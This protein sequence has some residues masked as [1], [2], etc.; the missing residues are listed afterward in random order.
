MQLDDICHNCNSLAVIDSLLTYIVMLNMHE[1][2]KMN[3]ETFV[4]MCAMFY[5]VT[6]A[7][8]E[9]VFNEME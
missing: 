7:R 1:N 2:T 9:M 6:I 5:D 3:R 8:N 4:E